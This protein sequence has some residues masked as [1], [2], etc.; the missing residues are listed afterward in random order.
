MRHLTVVRPTPT[1]DNHQVIDPLVGA[2]VRQVRERKLWRQHDLA[3]AAGVATNT[4]G[5]LEH[6]KQ[7]RWSNFQK[8]ADALGVTT[9]ALLTGEGFLDDNPLADG[10]NLSDEAVRTAQKFQAAETPIRLII[11]R[12]LK[13]GSR[14]PMLLLWDRLEH[15]SPHR[16]ETVLLTLQQQ[17]KLAAEERRVATTTPVK[18][19]K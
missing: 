11:T 2:R 17:E 14:D 18:V 9:H 3:E 19:K 13:A 10:L 12:L 6:G 4:V 15:L 7:T 1:G 16:K 8:I 5:G